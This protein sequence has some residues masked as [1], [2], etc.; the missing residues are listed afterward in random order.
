MGPRGKAWSRFVQGLVTFR[1]R[2]DSATSSSKRVEA[3]VNGAHVFR[4]DEEILLA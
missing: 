1:P 4:T 2:F 3:V